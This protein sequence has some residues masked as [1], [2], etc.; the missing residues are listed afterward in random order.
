MN[1]V[2]ESAPTRYEDPLACIDWQGIDREC[3]WLPPDALSLTGDERFEAL[4]LGTRRRLSQLEYVHLLQAG[5]WLESRFMAHMSVIAQRS[6]DPGH[7]ARLLHAIREEAGHS[8]L[9]VE[10]L[11][12]SGFGIDARHG[13]V[14]RA[15]DALGGLVAGDNA[16]FWAMVVIGEELPDRLN[17]RLR[18]GVAEATL[19][20]VVYRIASI[21]VHDEAQHAAYARERC[22][23]AARRLPRWARRLL[24]P[25]LSIAIDL[26]A[27][28]VY[29][30]P[31]GIYGR[32]G[33]EPAAGWRAR[34]LR[35]P[36]RRAQ[37]AAMI[38]PTVDF[39]RRSGW[40]VRSRFLDRPRT[41][42]S[43]SGIAC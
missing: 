1:S 17:Q 43:G 29:Y 7:R 34:A 13:P 26:Y 5:L 39:L 10:L 19:S 6:A 12:R 35:N 3:W 38:R 28:F 31:A 33:L 23:H 41:A 4:P 42:P 30:P 25:A 27:R 36:A 22:R 14:F 32:A 9:F 21:H 16:L 20:S 24:A 18:R 40:P 15:V 8:L 37:V 2:T 11:Q